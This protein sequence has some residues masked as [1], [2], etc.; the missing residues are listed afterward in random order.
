MKLFYE[1]QGAYFGDC[2]PFYH[3]GKFYVFH[4]RDKRDP[5]PF[6]PFESMSLT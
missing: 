1:P 5:Q 3:D 2:M 6:E 4:Q